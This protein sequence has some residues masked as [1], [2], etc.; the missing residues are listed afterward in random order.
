MWLR[1]FEPKEN[2]IYISEKI[3]SQRMYSQKCHV[4]CCVFVLTVVGLVGVSCK[5]W[6]VLG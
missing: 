5:D 6:E 2:K 1:E 3:K 4:S